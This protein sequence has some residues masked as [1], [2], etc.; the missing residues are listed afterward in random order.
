MRIRSIRLTLFSLLT[1]AAFSAAQ[2]QRLPAGVTPESYT[3][4][5]TPD[6]KAATFTGTESITIH[7]DAA[8]DTVTLNSAEIKILDV[9][10]EQACDGCTNGNGIRLTGTVAYD[11]DKEQ[12]TFTFPDTLRAGEATLH[13]H[14][15]GILN[16][17]LRGFYLS[18]TDRRNYAVTQFEPTDARRAFPS[19][20]EPAFKATYDL[21]LTVDK[22]DTVIAN[23]P[24][25]TDAPEDGG[26]HT[27]TFQTTPKMS[28]YLVAF[29][30]GDF[31][32]LSGSS[33]G[34][35][36]R[37]CATPDKVQYG[38]LALD[39]AEHTLHYYDTYFGIKYPMPKLDMI[40][41]PDF[42]AGAMEN[43]GAITYRE[44]DLL[45]DD[46]NAAIPQKKR[47]AVVVTHEMAHQ[48]FGDMVTMQWWDN[49]WLNEGFAT[50]MESKAANV[51]N[52]AWK[53]KQDDASDLDGELN[54]DAQATTR[55]IRAKADTP[56]EINEEFDGI[57]YQKAG[58]VIGMVEHYL[59]E[60]TFREGVHNYLAAHLY[61]NATAED[62]WNAQTATSHKPVDQIM[63]SFVTEAGVPL[64]TFGP[65]ARNKV[66]KSR[67]AVSQSRFYLSPTS[68]GSHVQHWTVPVCFKAEEGTSQCEIVSEAN[69]TIAVPRNKFFYA[70]ADDKGY[71]RSAYTADEQ[72]KIVAHAESDLSPAE[73]LGL[74][75]DTWSLMRSGQ[76]SVGGYLDL[77][78]AMRNDGEAMLQDAA[79]GKVSA[80]SDRIATEED[81]KRLKAWLVATYAPIYAKLP[82]TGGTLDEQQ[83]RAQLFGVLGTA[84][85]AE[86]LAE[87]HKLAE[88]YIA[89][90]DAVDPEVADDAVSLA[91]KSGD[92][93]LYEKLLALSKSA[94]NPD[95]QTTALYN[96]SSFTDPALVSRTLDYL[97]SGGVRNQDSWILYMLLLR[98]IE[99]REQTWEYI[100]AHW[101]QTKAQL[102]VASNARLVAATG[103][104]CSAAQ[105]DDVQSFFTANPLD[106]TARTLKQTI[107]TINDCTQL[108]SAQEPNLKLWLDHNAPPQ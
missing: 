92:A 91:A 31:Q 80:V 13:L 96:L 53:Y 37:V 15:T 58:A 62:F 5:L 97:S 49:L 83:L 70:N 42:E 88:Q 16:D 52:P 107:D 10:A 33:D 9:T 77:V 94:N 71:Y 61:A 75:G 99:T 63:Q 38:K 108:H 44:T 81:R 93:A 47:V 57:A 26:K 39:V 20:D 2:A 98:H 67:V 6:L 45:L 21:S 29:L 90:P 59:G 23:T 24:I 85:D 40:A 17:E 102:T 8:T 32:C 56:A 14:Y 19:W 78:A 66:E 79:L 101:A 72:A 1:L 65:E 50:W 95:V 84:G 74:L 87:A 7:M 34:V 36:I 27:I 35:P 86:I 4:A 22:G 12:A 100:K 11:T 41:L 28:T 60:E 46:A 106:A 73:R 104:F 103:V 43:F 25:L 30:V 76:G 69:Q 51:Y 89:N 105:R 18:K 3:L 64:L 55:T 68:T 48:W 54:E 82:A